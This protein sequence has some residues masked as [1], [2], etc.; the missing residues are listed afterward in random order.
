GSLTRTTTSGPDGGFDFP[1]LQ[2]GD[3][4]LKVELAGFDTR[5]VAL[6]L[7]VNQRVR[8]DVIL[9]PA[10]VQE[11]VSVV[12]AIPL[13]HANDIA[14]GEV[15]DQQQVRE[16]PLNGRQF[17]ELSLLVPGVHMSH[18]AQTGSTSALYWRPGQDSAI[19]I[20]GGRP[21]AN[22]YLLDGTT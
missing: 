21:N 1:G 14:I 10:G 17:L 12:Q 5:Q 2:P 15:I 19:T 7:E 3:Y 18:G 4:V 20:S 11:E 13:L 16:L 8:T 22:I 9:Q 6:K